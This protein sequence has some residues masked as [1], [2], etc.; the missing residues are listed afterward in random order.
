MTSTRRNNERGNALI[1]VLIGVVLFSALA[2]T[3]ARGFRSEG[4]SNLSKRQIDLSVSEI[5]DFSQKIERAVARLRMNGCSENEL[6]FENSTVDGYDFATRD[7]C[8]IFNAAG[9]KV[10]YV[11]PPAASVLGRWAFSGNNAVAG[12]TANEDL[13]TEKPEL[14]LLLSVSK[15]A[16]VALDNKLGVALSGGAPPADADSFVTDDDDPNKYTGAF[17]AGDELNVAGH[18]ATGCVGAGGVYYFFHT[19]I[20]R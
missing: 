11:P 16:C 18:P 17:G 6:S 1:F 8:K 3:V 9:G 19:L 5:L 10:S 2:F 13:G 7:E 20:K 14:L 15:D 12:M 4:T